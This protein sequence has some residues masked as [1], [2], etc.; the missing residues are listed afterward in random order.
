MIEFLSNAIY[1]NFLAIVFDKKV[2]ILGVEIKNSYY[3]NNELECSYFTFKKEELK[4]V[5]YS[6]E[7]GEETEIFIID[8]SCQISNEEEI[9]YLKK[10]M[11]QKGKL[12]SMS[13]LL[14]PDE[15]CVELTYLKK[16]YNKITQYD[17]IKNL[18]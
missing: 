17:I 11:L 7:M 13:L 8:L 4:R 18:I 10:D 3:R 9:E 12:S 5:L 15:G 6:L 1:D 16:Y 14:C 2:K